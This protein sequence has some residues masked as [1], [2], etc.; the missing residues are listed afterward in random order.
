MPE[1]LDNLSRMAYVRHMLVR[2]LLAL[3][4]AGL[5]ATLLSGCSSDSGSAEPRTPAAQL[6]A[7][8]PA[9]PGLTDMPN[10]PAPDTVAE[11]RRLFRSIDPYYWGAADVSISVRIDRGLRVWLYGDTMS[12]RNGFVHSTAIVQDGGNLHVSQDGEQLLPN[13]AE[14]CDDAGVCRTLIYW[15]ELVRARDDGALVVTA[16]PTSVGTGGVWDFHRQPGREDQSREGLLKVNNDGDVRFVKWLRYV[17][18]PLLTGDGEDFTVL[19]P[20][21]FT[22]QRVIHDIR[23]ADGTWLK[24]TCQN[25]DDASANHVDAD[26]EF[27]WADFRP[28]WASSPTRDLG[29]EPWPNNTPPQ[30]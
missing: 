4:S 18:R 22:Y 1:P 2:R 25:W 30:A 8:T 28:M 20:H 6:V 3:V 17:D 23:L 10:R 15:V 26:G 13:G 21:H 29:I 5:A 14:T 9:N 24:T 19:E 16:N 11:Y 7:A 27:Q 12:E